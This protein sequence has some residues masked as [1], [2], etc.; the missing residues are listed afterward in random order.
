MESSIAGGAVG[1]IDTGLTAV[2]TVNA[3]LCT[4]VV[5]VALQT[6]TAPCRVLTEE[7]TITGLAAC[8][9]GAAAG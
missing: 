9:G 1:T 3:Q 6:C 4:S 7:G 8:I 2:L 5:V